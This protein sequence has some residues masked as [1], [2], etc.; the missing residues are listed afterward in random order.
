MPPAIEAPPIEAHVKVD[1]PYVQC[2]RA[3]GRAYAYYRRD[4]RSVRIRGE[5]GSAEW[6]ESYRRIA[7][8][9]DR[10]ATPK[11]ASGSWAALVAEYRAAPEYLGLAPRTRADYARH[12]DRIVAANGPKSVAGLTRAKLLQIRDKVAA[13]LGGRV[14]DYH[15]A[16]YAILLTFAVDRDYRPDHPGRRIRKIHRATGHRP[17]RDDEIAAFRKA[18]PLGTW[19]RTAA[20]IA[21]NTGQR[22]GD[23]VRISWPHVRNGVVSLR[24]GK[25]GDWLEI[26]QTAELQAALEAWERTL[27]AKNKLGVAVL[28]GDRGKPVG[29]SR[30]DHRLAKAFKAAG[31]DGVTIHGW[32]YTTATILKELGVDLDVRRALLGHATVAMAEKY[33]AQKRGAKAAVESLDQ[34][35]QA[36]RKPKEV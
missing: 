13:K 25:T 36:A 1:L 26:P 9:W 18:W 28:I 29:K 2:V 6:L 12:L 20:E 16:V 21:L 22:G 11:P 30:F 31:L 3:R 8:T 5:I 19:E 33:A 7:A 35:A 32:R 24:Q 23:V 10:P 17:W 4:G 27:K 15:V 34:A 14:A